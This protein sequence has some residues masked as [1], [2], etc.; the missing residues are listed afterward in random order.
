M[1]QQEMIRAWASEV[2]LVMDQ[3]SWTDLENILELKW[4]GLK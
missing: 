1:F 3:S 2:N 4:I